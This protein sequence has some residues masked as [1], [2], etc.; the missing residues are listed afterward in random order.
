MPDA[1]QPLS[2]QPGQPTPASVELLAKA[3]DDLVRGVQSPWT[4][5]V[6]L[7]HLATAAAHLQRID[8]VIQSPTGPVAATRIDAGRKRRIWEDLMNG[9]ARQVAGL[10][11]APASPR[12]ALSMNPWV[13]GA[14]AASRWVGI[15]EPRRR[16]SSTGVLWFIPDI[17]P[18]TTFLMVIALLVAI[19]A[20][21]SSLGQPGGPGITPTALANGD[22]GIA[23]MASPEA[24][25]GINAPFI[26]PDASIDCTVKPR[27]Q[28]EVAAFL[29]DPGPVSERAYLPTTGVDPTAAVEI[30]QT[31]RTYSACGDKGQTYTRALETPRKIYEDPTN[32]SSMAV[33]GGFSTVSIAERKALSEALLDP[34]PNTYVLL[35][36]SVWTFEEA[37]AAYDA[38]ERAQIRQTMLPSHMVQLADGRFGG[39]VFF[40]ARSDGAD[41]PEGIDV[42]TRHWAFVDFLIFAPDA[43]RGGQWAVDERLALC[44]GDCDA[45]WVFESGRGFAPASPVAETCPVAPLTSEQTAAIRDEESTLPDRQYAPVTTADPATAHDV[46][47]F[48]DLIEPCNVAAESNPLDAYAFITDRFVA[49]NPLGI[50]PENQNQRSRS[51]SEQYGDA[52]LGEQPAGDDLDFLLNIYAAQDPS[53]ISDIG[54]IVAFDQHP[55]IVRLLPDGRAAVYSADVWLNRTGRIRVPTPVPGREVFFYAIFANQNGSW[56]LDESLVICLGD[57][58]SLWAEMSGTP[59]TP[60]GTPVGSPEAAIPA[61]NRE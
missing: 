38:G 56:L 44:A 7:A 20:G 48:F 5:D 15:A 25:F 46:R 2:H 6:P 41:S 16:T 27:P 18:T 47:S 58:D 3:L 43:S 61:A 32:S 37:N 1:S 22:R 17:Q 59:A 23:A 54:V 49:E 21:F 57:C 4:E 19:G 10:S 55:Q 24:P 52:L 50:S 39:P 36:D 42:S 14:E 35:S 26:D 9:S 29:Q 30:V 51:I 34:D 53:L 40:L 28:E 11:T 31:S 45:F 8:G 33:G 12:S 13:D 60:V